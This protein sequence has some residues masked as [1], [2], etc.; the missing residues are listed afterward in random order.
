MNITAP[1]NE[2]IKLWN[3]QLVGI[4]EC[5]VQEQLKTDQRERER[6]REG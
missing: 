3:I 2:P 5:G 6:D 4:P 1:E